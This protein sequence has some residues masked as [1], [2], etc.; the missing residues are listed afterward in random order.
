[1]LYASGQQFSNKKRNSRL[2]ENEIPLEKR[3]D[4][5]MTGGD[6]MMSKPKGKAPAAKPDSLFDRVASILDQ[7]R[8]NVVRAVNTNMVLAYWLIGREIV[9]EIQRGRGRAKYG[10]KVIEDLSARLTARYGRGFSRPVL[11]SFRQF[12][13]TYSDHVEILFPPGKE[14]ADIEKL[15]PMGRELPPA[16]IPRPTGVESMTKLLGALLPWTRRGNTFPSSGRNP[17]INRPA[18]YASE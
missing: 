1:V 11:W 14:L 17:R 9:E 2:D 15:F 16:P 8:K 3:K 12:Y 18:G 6:E 5:V 13:L 4:A 7:A 10:E